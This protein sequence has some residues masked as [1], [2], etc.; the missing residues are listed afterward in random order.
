MVEHVF[1]KKVLGVVAPCSFYDGH[2]HFAGQNGGIFN[3]RGG[4]S[5]SPNSNPL[6][7]L[8]IDNSIFASAPRT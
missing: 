6:E 4:Q 1:K 2:V 7:Q 8:N 5:I 3:L